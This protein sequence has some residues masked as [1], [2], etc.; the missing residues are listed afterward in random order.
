M[1]AEPERSPMHRAPKESLFV[2]NEQ[3][4]SS[5]NTHYDQ[6]VT[7]SSPNRILADERWREK[8]ATSV[9]EETEVQDGQEQD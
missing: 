2:L 9:W 4:N 1:T 6:T 3:Q 8:C 7:E 5:A